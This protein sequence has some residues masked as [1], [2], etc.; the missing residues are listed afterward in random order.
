VYFTYFPIK[1]WKTVFQ[2]GA[3]NNYLEQGLFLFDNINSFEAH[4]AY[5]DSHFA[6]IIKHG[7]GK[8]LFKKLFLQIRQACPGL[9]VK[10]DTRM[11]EASNHAIVHLMT[12]Q[13]IILTKATLQ[14]PYLTGCNVFTRGCH[15]LNWRKASQPVLGRTIP[16]LRRFD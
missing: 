4:K 2:K 11:I 9:H 15:I 13:D 14:S 1:N 7:T 16:M 10:E 8:T 3:H 5:V 6:P 12:R